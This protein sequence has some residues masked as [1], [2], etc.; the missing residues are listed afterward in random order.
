MQTDGKTILLAAARAAIFFLLTARALPLFHKTH[1][2]LIQE[3]AWGLLAVL[4]AIIVMLAVKTLQEVTNG[5]ICVE[6]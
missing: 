3:I 2:Q 5:R 4:I 1:N 6:E